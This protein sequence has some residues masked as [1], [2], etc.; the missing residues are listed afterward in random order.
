[1]LNVG[2]DD[3]TRNISNSSTSSNSADDNDCSSRK[4]TWIRNSDHKDICRTTRTNTCNTPLLE[5]RLLQLMSPEKVSEVI[6]ENT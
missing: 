2:T 1:M 4:D 3:G 5:K 6:T